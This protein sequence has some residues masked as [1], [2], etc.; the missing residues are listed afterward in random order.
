MN[1]F[2]GLNSRLDEAKPLFSIMKLKY[3]D[4]ENEYRG[5]RVALYC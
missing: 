3:I 5:K 4:S 1:E 2:R